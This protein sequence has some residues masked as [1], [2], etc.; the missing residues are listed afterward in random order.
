MGLVMSGFR[1]LD[2]FTLEIAAKSSGLM[3]GPID[4]I[5]QGGNSDTISSAKLNQDYR[6]CWMVRMKT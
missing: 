6:I 3:S 5:V 1:S 2:Q 4:L